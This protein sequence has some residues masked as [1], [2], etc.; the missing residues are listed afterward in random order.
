MCDVLREVHNNWIGENLE[1]RRPVNRINIPEA[2]RERQSV[3]DSGCQQSVLMI[4]S[5]TI[6]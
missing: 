3:K 2:P 6:A 5:Q 4:R 1:N